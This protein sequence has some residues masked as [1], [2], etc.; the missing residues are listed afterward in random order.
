MNDLDLA[1]IRARCDAA[2]KGPWF[3]WDRGVGFV[4]CHGY[5]PDHGSGLPVNHLPEG[6]RTDIGRAEDAVF[7]AA[8][9]AD[10]PALLSEVDRLRAEL[11]RVRAEAAEAIAAQIEFRA[12]GFAAGGGGSG[13]WEA[14]GAR[15][16]AAVAREYGRSQP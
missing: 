9:R 15:D 10:V 11:A 5:D 3:A 16:A 1:V 12:D 6:E 14:A 2:T 7:I 8:A 4:I 13:A